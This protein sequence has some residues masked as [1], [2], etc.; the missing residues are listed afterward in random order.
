MPAGQKGRQGDVLNP[1]RL[2]FIGHFAGHCAFLRPNYLSC[3]ICDFFVCRVT[4]IADRL[5]VD[6][7]LIHKERKRANEVSS[8]VLVG[9]VK[10]RVAI[11]VDDMAGMFCAID[12]VFFG[13]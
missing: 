5:N 9:D 13:A 2:V 3:E 4:A 6:F 8:M 7:A 11:L 10:D 12:G 1:F